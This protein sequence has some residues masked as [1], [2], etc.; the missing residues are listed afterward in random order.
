MTQHNE[1]EPNVARRALR[2]SIGNETPTEYGPAPV[3][4]SLAKRL[5]SVLH[6]YGLVMTPEQ[7]AAWLAAVEDALRFR[8]MLRERRVE[9]SRVRL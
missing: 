6:S 9:R 4:A 1:E 5:E 7:R 2:D 3:I 8:G